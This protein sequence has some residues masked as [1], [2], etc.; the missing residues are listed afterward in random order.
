LEIRLGDVNP[1]LSVSVSAPP[2]VATIDLI[3]EGGDSKLSLEH[4]QVHFGDST[5]PDR[6][7]EWED[8]Y[9]RKGEAP[10]ERSRDKKIGR[11][12]KVT[13]GGPQGK[14]IIYQKGY[15]GEPVSRCGRETWNTCVV[16]VHN[17]VK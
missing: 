2:N 6:S 16:H 13:K 10:R 14:L 1:H 15:R 9:P 5:T 12:T 4:F 3:A 17:G 8:V 11:A 7:Y